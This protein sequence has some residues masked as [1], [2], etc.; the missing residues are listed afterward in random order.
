[1][2]IE[3]IFLFGRL[4]VFVLIVVALIVFAIVLIKAAKKR[5]EKRN[6]AIHDLFEGVKDEINKNK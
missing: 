1:M 5:R 4:A 2:P 6:E 3:Y